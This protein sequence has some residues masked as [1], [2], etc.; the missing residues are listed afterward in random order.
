[1]L[2]QLSE[3]SAAATARALPVSGCCVGSEPDD[4]VVLPVGPGTRGVVL[5]DPAQ[6]LHLIHTGIDVGHV[7]HGATN[8]NSPSNRCTPWTPHR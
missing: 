4:V 2:L 5:S 3:L 6:S 1:M 7:G 8:E